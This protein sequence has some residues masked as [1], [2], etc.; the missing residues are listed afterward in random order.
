MTRNDTIAFLTCVLPPE[1]FY[2]AAVFR[3][4]T[5]KPWHSFFDTIE[6]LADFI[7]DQ[8]QLGRT[9]YHACASFRSPTR[10]RSDN[11]HL[12]RSFWLDIDCGPDKPYPDQEA[13]ARTVVGFCDGAGLPRPLFVDSG[14][15]LHCYWPLD[16]PLGPE[17]WR[18]R[19]AALKVLCQQHGLETD[20]ARTADIASI[21]RT[22]GTHNRK[23]G[24]RLVLFDSNDLARR[25]IETLPLERAGMGHHRASPAIS[26]DR[27]PTTADATVGRRSISAAITSG[28][29]YGAVYADDV[30][31][32]CAQLDL[33]RQSGGVAGWFLR[34]GVLA[35]CTDGEVKAHEWSANDYPEYDPGVVDDRL[36][37]SRLLSGAT[38]C[39]RLHGVDPE[40]CERCPFWGRIKSPISVSVSGNVDNRVQRDS[41]PTGVSAE[42]NGAHYLPEG[43]EARE[44]KLYAVTEGN[45]G[46]KVEVLLCNHVRLKSVQTGELDR[47]SHSYC[48][49][50]HLPKKGW[51]D[52]LLDAKVLFSSSGISEL[53][54]KGVVIHD[55]KMFMNYARLIVDDFNE[56]SATH[57]RYDQFGWKNENTSFL[58]GKML[59]TSVGPVEAIGAKEV[60]T[61]SQWI[62]PRAKGNVEAWTEAADALFASDMEAYSTMVLASF[63]APLM[64]FQSADEGGAILHLF[65]PGSGQGKTTALNAAWTVWGSKEGLALTNEDTRVSKPIAIGTLANLP[66]IYDELRDKDPEYIR[67]MV[68]MF[69]EGRDRMRGMVDG[70]I[71]HTKA[72]WQTIMLSAANNSLIDQLQGDGVDA[73]AFRVLEMS[74]TLSQRIDKTKGDR[75]KRILNDNAGHAGDAYLRYLLHPP[76]LEFARTSLDQWTQEI[77]D[78]TR[79][80][81]AHRFRVRAVGAIAVASAL[82]NKLGIL[83]FQTDRILAWLIRELGTGKNVGTVSASLPAETAINALGEFINEH[84]GEML[85]V[86]HEWRPRKERMTPIVRPQHRLSIRYEIEPQ[87]VFISE[88]VFR[89][90]ALKKQLSPRSV[91]ETLEKTLVVTNRK[92]GIT[93]SAG[94]DIPGA[95]VMCI[96]INAAHPTMSGLVASVSEL[97]QERANG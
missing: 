30:A 75:L 15:G 1:G 27:T 89:E 95:Q 86:R 55:A 73:P 42:L 46:Q 67:K 33:L 37:R 25:A 79:L 22:P 52:V 71:R 3:T 2:C 78:I 17:E 81:S 85:V 96:E 82:V 61:R 12:A 60:E 16:V 20:P 34:V 57:V 56:Q 54:G 69:T 84:L 36:V 26:R 49:E 31:D 7:L 93:L 11:A 68:V 41:M 48:F 63:A 47:T 64:R 14:F 91:V 39:E 38:T 50:H 35:F 80:D 23:Q 62:G 66:V 10:R 72:N 18:D 77:W 97:Q 21:L 83:H 13:A 58:Y 29:S 19:A 87:R 43:F 74:S 70:T 6:R 53:A 45:K 28:D 65:T 24:E 8:D 51:T 76:V 9:V 44:N 88:S 94:T 5:S 4:K 40:I 92:R 32:R 90:W 59:Y